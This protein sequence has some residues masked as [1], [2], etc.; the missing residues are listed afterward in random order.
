MVHVFH[1]LG[2]K[3][4]QYPGDGL[5]FAWDGQILPCQQDRLPF[6]LMGSL[7]HFRLLLPL[8]FVLYHAGSRNAIKQLLTFRGLRRSAEL[9]YT[10]QNRKKDTKP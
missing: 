5:R 3:S 2:L 8:F 4:A 1:V 9:C 7:F 6:L 10:G